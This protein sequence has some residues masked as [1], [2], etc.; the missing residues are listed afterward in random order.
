[1]GTIDA[2]APAALTEMA[3]SYELLEPGI[4]SMIFPDRMIAERE[5][6]IY[7]V[8]KHPTIAPV[9][10]P[11]RI[12]PATN[13]KD[14][15][16]KQTFKPLYTRD[17]DFIEQYVVNTLRSLE[18]P[19]Q[20]VSAAE[21][22]AQKMQDL[23]RRQTALKDLLR[24]QAVLGGIDHYD[25]RTD[26]L[27]QVPMNIPAHNLFRFDGYDSTVAANTTIAFQA[28]TANVA[29]ANTKGRKEALYFQSTDGRFGVSH[30]DKLARIPACFNMIKER[31]TNANKVRPTHLLMS[32]SYYSYI[33]MYNE[34]LAVLNNQVGYMNYAV[35]STDRALITPAK[36]VDAV[37]QSA[38]FNNGELSHIAGME[39]VPI[40]QYYED[41]NEPG[42]IKS[43]WP[44]HIVAMVAMINPLTKEA[45]GRTDYPIGESPDGTSG[46]WSVSSDNSASYASLPGRGMTVGNCFLPYLKFPHFV[47]L[48]EVFERDGIADLGLLDEIDYGYTHI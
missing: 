10:D 29:L 46:I 43:M 9:V 38:T 39:V 14:R 32:P 18:N 30:V 8:I 27:I 24:V 1:M 35:N 4:L 19:S 34:E 26:V 42:S 20:M 45:P 36:A 6:E 40:R 5:V 3:R 17:S 23:I 44:D 2:L 12:A 22:V 7:Q 21:L 41:P 31:V 28:L 16:Y 47:T 15:F 11:G 25:Q 37:T 33:T 13:P 48:I